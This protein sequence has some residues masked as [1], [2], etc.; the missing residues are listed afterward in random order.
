MDAS[1]ADYLARIPSAALEQGSS[2]SDPAETLP[3]LRSQ[4]RVLGLRARALI[5]I[6]V[7]A[8]EMAFIVAAWACVGAGALN[9]RVDSGWLFA[10]GACIATLLP[11]RALG[12]WLEALISIGLGGLLRERFLAGVLRT[13][14]DGIQRSGVGAL[15]GRVLEVEQ[16]EQAGVTGGFAVL[17]AVVELIAAGVVLT[18]GAVPGTQ[19]A[20]LLVWSA[21]AALFL[22]ANARKRAVW[23]QL[24]LALT[25]RLVE[26][27]CAHRTRAVQQ[28]AS[29]RH[30]VDDADLEQYAHVSDRLDRS[31]A[32]L[33]GLL[34]QAYAIVAIAGLVPAFLAGR[35]TRAVIA[36]ATTL[37]GIL[38]A[39]A[40]FRKLTAGYADATAAIIAWRTMRPLM[41]SAD[42]SRPIAGHAP[43]PQS[44]K[45][46][47]K[48]IVFRHE[49]RME[50]VLA[51]CSI[52]IEPGNFILLEG[53]SGS[54]KSTLA[55]VLAGLRQPHS[56]LILSGGFDPRS[57]GSEWC[58]H[59]TLAPQYHQNHVF[60]A[61]LSFNLLL[62][63]PWPHTEGDL[64]D[65][66]A[67]AQELGLGPLIE[68]M[69]SG[70]EQWVG[71]TGWQLSQGER[72]RVF[73]ARALLQK[74]RVIVLDEC[75]A[76]LDPANLER[77]VVSILRNAPSAL[78]IA[79]P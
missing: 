24:R 62:G 13:D 61:P 71:E 55:A 41:E 10:A 11:L 64:A 47:A 53:S 59:V 39:A 19:L 4:I 75:L 20:L 74:A 58:R 22:F 67:L 45:L 3:S 16:I 79:H 77:C 25:A 49:G 26:N 18:W 65:A 46:I 76:A 23:T 63:R 42:D 60:S 28:P 35:E 54:G 5:L 40:A 50:P 17:L 8:I 9:D 38:L 27:L 2:L 48:D 78:V 1:L 32:A 44:G 43:P 12:R 29:H 70:L 37:G 7:Y 33:E 6:A 52:T 15:F 72:S 66:R 56:G 57:V 69:P 68:R 51:Q 14:P 36:L 73:L 21:V 30:D 31:S 34:P